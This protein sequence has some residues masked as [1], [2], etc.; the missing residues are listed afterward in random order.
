M[1]WIRIISINLLILLFCNEWKGGSC[2]TPVYYTSS[3]LH[4][5]HTTMHRTKT[6]KFLGNRVL[7]Y[8]NSTSTFQISLTICEDVSPNPGPHSECEKQYHN[9]K[10]DPQIRL[11]DNYTRTIGAAKL[12]KT[13]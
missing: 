12:S 8:S 9:I 4:G 3:K 6:L 10:Y 7:Y 2:N 5:P 11:T 1:D 13:E